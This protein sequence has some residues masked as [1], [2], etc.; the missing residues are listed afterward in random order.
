[1]EKKR[2]EETVV[3][4][5]TRDR[6][7]LLA[8]I[9]DL[10]QDHATTTEHFHEQINVLNQQL[11]IANGSANDINTQLLAELSQPLAPEPLPHNPCHSHSCQVT[12]FLGS[13]PY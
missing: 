3:P 4:T 2:L 1:M 5:I 10:Q 6:D 8:Q 11:E 13:N 7:N 9:T 12:H